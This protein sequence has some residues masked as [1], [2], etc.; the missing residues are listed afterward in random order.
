MLETFRTP[1]DV[2]YYFG[3]F[4]L[5]TASNIESLTALNATP[6]HIP[7][8]PEKLHGSAI[9]PSIGNRHKIIIWTYN[10]L[11]VVHHDLDLHFLGHEYGNANIS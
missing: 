1:A 6:T 9:V 8:T 5:L 4:A 3:F 11:Y 7:P 2:N 10:I